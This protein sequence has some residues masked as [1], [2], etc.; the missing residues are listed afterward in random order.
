MD[1]SLTW[2]TK[3]VPWSST[4]ACMR[5]FYDTLKENEWVPH[6]LRHTAC[7]DIW[8]DSSLRGYA[9]C[10]CPHD[11]RFV[12]GGWYGPWWHHEEIHILELR[13]AVY[14]IRRAL[15]VVPD[16][17]ILTV[18][19][20]NVIAVSLLRRTRGSSWVTHQIIAP[21]AEELHDKNC[22]LL[23]TWVESARM[24]ADAWTRRADQATKAQF[25][26]TLDE[27]IR[28]SA[29]QVTH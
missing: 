4:I 22:V 18:Y 6:V 28:H 1:G 21:M 17:T 24:L 15:R 29:D 3:L 26:M 5:S 23:L 14:A 19:C 16:N 2:A 20:D 12:L 11:T 13:V 7:F 25:G 27:I 8:T 9:A 10:F